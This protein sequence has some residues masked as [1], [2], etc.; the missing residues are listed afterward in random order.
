[1][2]EE[3]L[4]MKRSEVKMAGVEISARLPFPDR[5]LDQLANCSSKK[6]GSCEKTG[7]FV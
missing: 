1:M 6:E 5:Q 7:L 2:V 4:M 3:V